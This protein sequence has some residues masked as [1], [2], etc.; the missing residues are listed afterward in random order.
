M[1]SN[2]SQGFLSALILSAFL[3]SGC[4]QKQWRDPL[5]ENEEKAAGQV[6]NRLL[7]LQSGCSES[8]DAEINATWKSRVSD[9]GINGYLQTL[10]PSDIKVIAIN[11]LGQP[12][13]AFATNGRRFQTI[14]V[15]DRVYKHG[16]VSSFVKKHSIPKNILHD[17]WGIWLTGRIPQGNE[18]LQQLRQDELQRG[19]WLSI[20]PE[21][22]SGY[23]ADVFLLIDQNSQRLLERVATDKDGNEVAR[24]LY[25]NWTAIDNCPIP[26]SIEIQSHSYGT[27]IHIELKK[28]KTDTIFKESDM[29]L[30]PPRGFL[31]QYYP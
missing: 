17:Q 2:C 3:F 12:Q 10:L 6:V 1:K 4:A 22:K 18:D 21:E 20:E 7:Q 15:A 9:G 28:I 13:Y 11:P 8:I 26:T 16:R 19:F 29:S 30:K 5:G 25:K 14:N 24:V 23:F 31:Q 27:S